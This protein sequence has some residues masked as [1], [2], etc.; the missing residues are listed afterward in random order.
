MKLDIVIAG[1]GGQGTV[2]ASRVLAQ[3]AMEAGLPVRT[4][5]TIGMAQREGT[6]TSHVRI[7]EEGCPLF[8]ALIPDES[9]DILLGFELAETVRSL[10]KLKKGG[11]V[12]ANS[13]RI[14]PVSV[15]AG[16]SVYDEKALLKYLYNKVGS[17]V[18]F[19]AAELA[20]RAGNFRAANTVMLGALSTV[21]ELPFSYQRL[22]SSILGMLP[23]KLRDINRQAFELGRE[24]VGEVLENGR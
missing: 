4:S 23:E 21:P 5:E 9:A 11:R 12:F 6:V 22:L 3:A 24:A 16:R 17:P 8:G 13:A 7:G 10:H 15:A 19:D 20:L 14:V 1:V 2:L 18:I